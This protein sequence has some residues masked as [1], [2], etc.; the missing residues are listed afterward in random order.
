MIKI[1]TNIQVLIATLGLLLFVFF[2]AYNFNHGER[3]QHLNGLGWDGAAYAD[4]AQRDSIEVL[5]GNKISNYYVFI[6]L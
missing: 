5:S 4:W 6:F 3:I 2:F 1:N